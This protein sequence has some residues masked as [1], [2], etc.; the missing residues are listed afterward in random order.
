MVVCFFFAY[1]LLKQFRQGRTHF[2]VKHIFKIQ[3]LR[4]FI[5]RRFR[6]Q[7]CLCGLFME[8]DDRRPNE[9]QSVL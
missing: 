4:K 8:E 9:Q 5:L 6:G 7:N 2:Q 1:W 3:A